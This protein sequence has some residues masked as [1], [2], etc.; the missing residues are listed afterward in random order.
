MTLDEQEKNDETNPISHNPLAVDEL[1]R[2]SGTAVPAPQ[3]LTD[4]STGIRGDIDLR[5]AAQRNSNR[6]TTSYRSHEPTEQRNDETKPIS[7][8]PH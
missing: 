7:D 6:A 5:A 2:G 1:R 3:K 4:R 8:N